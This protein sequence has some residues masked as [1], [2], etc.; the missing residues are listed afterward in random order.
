MHMQQLEKN[1]IFWKFKRLNYFYLLFV[2]LLATFGVLLLYGAAHGSWEPYAQRHLVRFLVGL[3]LALGIAITPIRLI[4]HASYPL[5]FCALFL[6]L[7]VPFIG[8]TSMGATRWIDLGFMRLQPSEIAKIGLI[9]AVAKFYH[10]RHALVVDTIPIFLLVSAMILLPAC[11][12]VIQPDLGTALLFVMVGLGIMF[13]AG[14]NWRYFAMITTA[15]IA[16]MPIAWQ[17]LLHDYQKGRVLTF[18][19]PS[20]DPTG[21][22]YHIIQSKIAIGSAGFWGK[23]FMQGSQAQLKF[24][25]EKHTDFI[26]TLMTE[27]FG[28]AAALGVIGCYLILILMGVYMAIRNLNQYASLVIL[29]VTVTLFVYAFIN[30]AMVIG[31]LPVVGLPLPF[32]SF[33]GTSLLTL[34]IGVGLLLNMDINRF[35]H[36]PGAG[37]LNSGKGY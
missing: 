6:L 16:F 29:G 20:R 36:I 1:T 8:V 24:L 12:T 34:M 10:Q 15:G 17:F 9:L 3:I 26:F 11:L 14:V 31:L 19:D 27:D 32:I 37:G 33:G 13:F 21:A 28:M 4:Y 23:G 22:G 18:L 5:Y 7:L 35:T 2:T 30:I 25:P